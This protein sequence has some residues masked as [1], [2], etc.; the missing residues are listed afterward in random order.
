MFLL[1]VMPALSSEASANLP[2][3]PSVVTSTSIRWLSVPP[4]TS[5]TPPLISESGQRLR[6]INNPLG[7]FF[8]FRLQC[9]AKANC[10]AG[11]DV[12]QRPALNAGKYV[13]VQI[14]GVIGATHR[15][16]GTRA[17]QRF[18]RCRGHK[19]GDGHRVIVQPCCDQAG[20]VRHID[21][22]L[23]ANFTSDLRELRVRNFA[24]ISTCA[25]DDQLGFVFACQSS[26]LIEIQI[27][28]Y[29]AS[30]R[31][32]RSDTACRKC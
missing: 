12:H 32:R 19:I 13:A 9:F 5:R 26:H 7:V 2:P 16:T 27:A 23:G 28:A 4:L 29:R 30:R 17:A 11:D 25:G 3:M 18:V 24:R 31:R 22:Q 8:E 14:F 15:Q 10:L 1:T 6:V 21:K 20:I